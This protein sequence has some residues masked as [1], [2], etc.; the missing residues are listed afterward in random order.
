MK[1]RPVVWANSLVKNE[2]QWI[3]YSLKS[4]LP[5]VDR[6]I[7]WDTGSTDKTVEIVKTIKSKKI[8]FKKI[9]S[10]TKQKY[11]KI[12]QQMLEQAKSDWVFIVDGDEIW[13]EKCIVK[14]MRN[15]REAS[16]TINTFCVK[17]INFVGDIRFVHPEVFLGQTPHGPKG[18]KGFYSNRAFRRDIEGLY[19]AGDYGKE[20][21]YDS[22]KKI[23]LANKKQVKFLTDVYYWHMSYLPRSSSRTNDRQVMMRDKKRK[24]EIGIPRPSWVEIPKVFYLKRPEIASDPFYK[25]NQWQ[26]FKALIQTPL[27]KVKRKITGWKN[28]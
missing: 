2:E 6:A 10:V 23:L 22:S 8:S 27:K 3:W 26:Y 14:L 4:I 13:P 17:P 19:A 28:Q 7:V 12:R 18:L 25:M 5:F 24:F 9:G 15:I 21:F 11:G 16:Q 20:G 1:K